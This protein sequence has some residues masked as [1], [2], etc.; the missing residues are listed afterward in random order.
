[1]GSDFSE[2]EPDQPLEYIETNA[3]RSLIEGFTTADPSRK[4]LMKDLAKYMGIGPVIVGDPAQVADELQEWVD[5]GA[6][7]FNLT[8]AVTPDT[9]E[10]F[11]DYW[12]PELQDRG[13]MQME[14]KEGTI[15]EKLFG[16]GHARLRA[17]HPAVPC[18]FK[19]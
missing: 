17:P 7:G 3:F 9:F 5:H 8:F 1:M 15:R 18:R 12:V 14:Y 2:Y 16:P 19:R 13:M 11:V 10:D 4:W 6:H